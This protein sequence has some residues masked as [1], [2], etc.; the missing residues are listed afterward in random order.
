MSQ[1]PFPRA[2]R[3]ALWVAFVVDACLVTKSPR[4]GT[5]G[6]PPTVRKHVTDPAP[7]QQVVFHA[8]RVDD[9]GSGF[10]WYLAALF[11]N[12][13]KSRSPQAAS[14]QSAALGKRVTLPR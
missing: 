10:I 1:S 5:L 3:L 14:R 7:P 8:R 12:P 11:W 6:P 13:P 2:A 9:E 4:H